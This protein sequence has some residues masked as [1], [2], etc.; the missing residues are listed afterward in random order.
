MSCRECELMSRRSLLIKSGAAFGALAAADPLMRMMASSYA[1]TAGG[2]GNIL[3]L[4]QLNGGLD[5]LSFLA[6]FQNATYQALRPRL[7]LDAT[8][9]NPLPDNGEYG[10]NKQFQFFSDLYALGQLAIVQQIGYPDAN[11]SHFES[12]E[13]FE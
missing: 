12:Q 1:Q 9:V 13:I 7:K 4:C 2:T 10:I 11:G 6:P 5:C 8:M 3:V